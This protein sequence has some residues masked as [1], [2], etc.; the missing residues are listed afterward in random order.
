MP[1]Y[2]ALNCYI[3]VVLILNYLLIAFIVPSHLLRFAYHLSKVKRDIPWLQ[4]CEMVMV[5]ARSC[6]IFIFNLHHICSGLHNLS[7]F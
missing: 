5:L 7:L 6:T 2:I 4:I 3:G 1:I